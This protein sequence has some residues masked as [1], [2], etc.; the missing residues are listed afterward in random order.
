MTPAVRFGTGNTTRHFDEYRR[1]LQAAEGSGFDMLTCGDSQSLWAECFSLMTFAATVTTR[2]HLAIT[3]S[4]PKTR[5]PVTSASASVQQISGGR[6]HYGIAS[7]DSALRNIGV[8]AGTVDELEAYVIAVQGMT[9]KT[10][11]TWN[12]Q[13]LAPA[14]A[15]RAHAR[16]RLGRGRGAEDPAHGG[17]RRRRRGPVELP[18]R[19]TARRRPRASRRRRSEAGRTLDDIEIWHMVNLLAPTE[20]EG[21][22]SIA[23]VLAGTANHVFRFTL[24]GKGL[25]DELKEPMRG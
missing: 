24:D 3:V 14:L 17:S 18:H 19:G 20:A 2:P 15:R 1:W 25:P 12:G 23:S 4:N 5:H 21:I 13:A 22:E 16:P 8:A 7:G 10:P 9:A 11:V 6:F